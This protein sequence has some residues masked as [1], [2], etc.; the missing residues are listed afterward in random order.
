MFSCH[1]FVLAL[2]FENMANPLSYLRTNL[3]LVRHDPRVYQIGG[4][5]IYPLCLKVDAVNHYHAEVRIITKI[6][7][8]RFSM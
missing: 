7:K 6:Y 3:R 4:Y 8:Q 1:G 5:L 2:G